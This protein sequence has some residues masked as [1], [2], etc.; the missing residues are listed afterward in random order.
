MKEENANVQI[1]VS[2]LY[3]QGKYYFMKNLFHTYV[4]K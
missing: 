3:G 1:L 4:F 2:T